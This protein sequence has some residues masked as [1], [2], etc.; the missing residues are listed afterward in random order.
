MG[1]PSPTLSRFFDA[2]AKSG[3]LLSHRLGELR[4]AMSLSE[5]A[6]RWQGT[7][8]L[9]RRERS[10]GRGLDLTPGLARAGFP[11]DGFLGLCNLAGL[12]CAPVQPFFVLRKVWRT[13]SG[14]VR[15]LGS[16]EV[17]A[18]S[19]EEDALHQVAESLLFL[20]VNMGD[21]LPRAEMGQSVR[22]LRV[23]GLDDDLAVLDV[24]EGAGRAGREDGL[25]LL[26]HQPA[27]DGSPEF[28]EEQGGV[29]L[30]AVSWG[31]TRASRSRVRG[32]GFFL[33]P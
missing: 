24:G 33:R 20:Q 31:G 14:L 19:R 3:Q 25:A 23:G 4:S 16:R 10:L 28:L 30:G 11:G 26:G 8:G 29:G 27:L 5:G 1:Q 22:D 6:N 13:P 32:A 18:L 17:R 9:K 2:R 15:P 21:R 7:F 12:P